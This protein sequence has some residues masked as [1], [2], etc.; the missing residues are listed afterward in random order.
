MAIDPMVGLLAAFVLWVVAA[1]A[2]G[3]ACEALLVPAV[4]YQVSALVPVGFVHRS[5]KDYLSYQP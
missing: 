3:W 1:V 2:A 4:Y 5:K